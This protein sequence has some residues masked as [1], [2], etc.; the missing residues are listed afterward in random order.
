MARIAPTVRAMP[1]AASAFATPSRCG[2]ARRDGGAR[3]ERAF[4]EP[5]EPVTGVLA[6]EM[7]ASDALTQRR[8]LERDLAGRREGST[9]PCDHGSDGQSMKRYLMKFGRMPR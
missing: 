9:T 1:H 2:N 8:P 4:H 5:H 3:F 7:E 6:G